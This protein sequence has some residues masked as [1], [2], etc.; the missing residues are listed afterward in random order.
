MF[1]LFI[2]LPRPLEE[3]P[4]EFIKTVEQLQSLCDELKQQKEFSVD[5]EVYIF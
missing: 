4:L 3:T 2:K 5:L 1:Y